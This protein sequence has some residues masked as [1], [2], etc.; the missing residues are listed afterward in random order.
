[1]AAERMVPMGFAMS[2]PAMSG[3]EPWM[4]SYRPQE[5]APRLEEGIIPMEPVIMEASSDR[6]S[7]NMFSVTTTSN[8]LGSL[9]ICMAQLSTSISLS[10]TSGYSAARRCITDF[11][12][13]EESSTLLFSTEQSFL[14][15]FRAVSKPMRPMRSIS[16]SEYRSSSTATFCPFSSWVSWAPK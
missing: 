16:L 13:R 6:M 8:W 2:F 5:V 9:T 4:G 12:R 15:R 10:S 11:Q 7:P 14:P 3:A 1:M